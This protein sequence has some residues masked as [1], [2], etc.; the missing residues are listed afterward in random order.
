VDIAAGG[1]TVRLTGSI[2]RVDYLPRTGKLRVIDYKYSTGVAK[3][4]KLLKP[5]K[6]CVE[7]FQA[8]IYLF[9]ALRLLGATKNAAGAYAA[10][11]SLK[12]EPKATKQVESVFDAA[13]G[14]RALKELE[15]SAEFGAGI[16]K[17][18]EKIEGGDFS[19]T[20]AN[21]TFCPFRRACRYM[22]VRK[23]ETDE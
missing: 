7:S 1:E 14:E 18:V 15:S 3:Y 21:C 13:G 20:P 12:R 5:E 22:E 9:A 6:F 23:V 8:P 19:V 10:Y 2:D 11:I 17:L 16:M 4:E